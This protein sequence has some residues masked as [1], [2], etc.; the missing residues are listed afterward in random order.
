[1]SL[2]RSLLGHIIVIL[3]WVAPSSG[4]VIAYPKHPEASSCEEEAT[5]IYYI[6]DE[7]CKS[8]KTLYCI[9]SDLGMPGVKTPIPMFNNNQGVVD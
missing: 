2:V 6:M 9:M 3:G 5:N 4:G 8:S 1:M 7:G